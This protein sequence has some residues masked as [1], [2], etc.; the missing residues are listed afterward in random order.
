MKLSRTIP[1]L[2]AVALLVLAAAS[3]TAHAQFSIPRSVI[4]SG[5]IVNS[6]GGGYVMGATIGQPVIGWTNGS[7]YNLHQGFWFPR[8]N[9]SLS[10]DAPVAGVDGARNWPNPFSTSTTIY[11]SLS[12]RSRVHLT[13]YN[14]A[15]EKV[16]DLFNGTAEAGDQNI[17][18]DGLNDAGEVVGAGMYIFAVDAFGNG[19]RPTLTARGKMV[20]V[21]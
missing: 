17:L 20:V 18:W 10:V 8:I 3:S 7:S 5:G 15:G 6:S 4:A 2:V 21:R 16:R 14:A 19:G 11:Y 13:V 12:E 9:G 1:G